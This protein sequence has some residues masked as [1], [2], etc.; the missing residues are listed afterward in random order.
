[1][2]KLNGSEPTKIETSCIHSQI[3]SHVLN[4]FSLA[5]SEVEFNH[6]DIIKIM[7]TCLKEL[8]GCHGVLFTPSNPDGQFIKHGEGI[9]YYEHGI[10]IG[11]FVFMPET[12]KS[13][14]NNVELKQCEAIPSL[15]PSEIN[16]IKKVAKE[17]HKF[18]VKRSSEFPAE[19]NNSDKYVAKYL[20]KETHAN[21]LNTNEQAKNIKAIQQARGQALSILMDDGLI[22]SP[23]A[24]AFNNT[25]AKAMLI[26]NL[27]FG[28]CLNDKYL[29]AKLMTLISAVNKCKTELSTYISG[30][31]LSNK[32]IRIEKIAQSI[33]DNIDF[34]FSQLD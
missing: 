33:R 10:H 13:K 31:N 34:A 19:E 30:D 16:M 29:D 2:K 4:V 1:M 25:N 5:E 20:A 26:K 22:H 17:P 21:D 14:E 9:H 28:L 24:C 12:T 15:T 3:A 23:A 32:M 7:G 18:T 6:D 11:R 27:F 8:T